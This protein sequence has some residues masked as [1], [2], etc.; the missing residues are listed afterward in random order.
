[1]KRWMKFLLPAVLGLLSVPESGAL[2]KTGRK[3]HFAWGAEIGPSIDV[4]G[5]DMS[6]I[7]IGGF[8]GWRNDFIDFAGVGAGINMLMSHSGRFFPVYAG[9]RS[10]FSRSQKLVFF[11]ARIGC[12][13]ATDAGSPSQQ[14]FY[15]APGIGFNLASGKTYTSYLLVNYSYCSL[16]FPSFRQGNEVKGV[17]RIGMT[18]GITF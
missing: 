14:V 17:N 18:I 12:T 3:G 15:V 9:F 11:D 10:S 7:D 5:D 2:E 16:K 13:F 8:I 1:M 4:C 6:T